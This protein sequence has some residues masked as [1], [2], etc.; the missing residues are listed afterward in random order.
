MEVGLGVF[1]N[2]SGNGNF[3]LHAEGGRAMV[4]R[5]PSSKQ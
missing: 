1:G 2:R 4:G 5:G 3:L